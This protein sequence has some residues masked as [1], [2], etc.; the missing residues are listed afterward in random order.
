M[1]IGFIVVLL[2][3]RPVMASTVAG[4]TRQP[5]Y[6]PPEDNGPT[7]SGSSPALSEPA[8][9][10]TGNSLLPHV[11]TVCDQIYKAVKPL[12]KQPQSKFTLKEGEIGFVGRPPLPHEPGSPAA[13]ELLTTYNNVHGMSEKE[14]REFQADLNESSLRYHEGARD[15]LIR[16]YTLYATAHVPNCGGMSSSVA[17]QLY[18]NPRL[19]NPDVQVSILNSRSVGRQFD[20]VTVNL[21]AKGQPSIICDAWQ[22]GKDKDEA[23]VCSMDPKK[24]SEPCKIYQPKLWRVVEKTTLQWPTHMTKQQQKKTIEVTDRILRG[25]P[26]RQKIAGEAYTKLP[27]PSA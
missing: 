13:M 2:T 4:R 23:R 22:Q 8:S 15:F 7:C 16:L 26:A 25:L 14:I 17:A 6:A 20:H 12:N 21:T 5:D 19:R 1:L 10:Q 11:K 24:L 27:R 18:A 9:Y 3:G